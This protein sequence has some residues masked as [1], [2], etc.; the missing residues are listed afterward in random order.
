MAKMDYNLVAIGAGAAG[1]VTSYIGAVSKAK[2]ALVEKHRMGGDCLYTGC[3]PSK[4]LISN[5]KVVKTLK[6]HEAFGL[7]NVQ[8]SVNFSQVM[9][10]IQEIIRKIEPHDSIERFTRLG[11]DCYQGEA[12]LISPHEL[13]INEKIISAR[14]IVIATGARPYIPP[15]PG[16]ETLDYLHSDNLW[17]LRELPKRLLVVGG[18]PIGCELAQAFGRLGSEVTVMDLLP[19][20]M[21]REDPE[22]VKFVIDAFEEDGIR[23]LTGVKLVRF[24]KGENEDRV[25]YENAGY[26]EELSFDRV[27]IATGRKANSQGFGLEELGLALNPNGTIKVDPYLRT[28]QP[29][30]YAC[31]DV[32]GPYQ[33]THMAAH[34]AWYCAVNALLSPFKKFRVDYSVVPWCTY[35]DP[36]VA[37]VGLSETEAKAQNIPYELSTYGLDDLDRAITEGEDSGLIKVLTVPGKDR[38][39]GAVICGYHAGDLLAEFVLAMKHGLGMNKILGTIHSYPTFSEGAKYAAGEWKKAHVSENLL[40]WVEKFHQF[41]R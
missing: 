36:E 20:I 29:N 4:A 9:E 31:G 33:F 6:E 37:R 8:Y 41:R 23:I 35:T 3:V 21:P 39:I 13:K 32:A 16:I 26:E 7:E 18:G 2:V 17:D 10:R 25:I 28:S 11:V 15:I 5:A 14:N 30:I 27:I 38:I 22:I 19:T 1:L 34:Q 24:E 12:K 40:K